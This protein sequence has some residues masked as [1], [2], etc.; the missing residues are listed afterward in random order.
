M[1]ELT[2]RISSATGLGTEK[3]AQAIGTLTLDYAK[4]KAGADLVKQVARRRTVTIGQRNSDFA[5]VKDG[6]AEGDTVILHP[7]DRIEDG[8]RISIAPAT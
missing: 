5:E 2:T 4:E 1:Q 3:S 7:S 6:L 8:T